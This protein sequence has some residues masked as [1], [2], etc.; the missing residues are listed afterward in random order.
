MANEDYT[1]AT[2]QDRHDEPLTDPETLEQ[3]VIEWAVEV[4]SEGMYALSTVATYLDQALPLEEGPHFTVTLLSALA[5]FRKAGM[6]KGEL[7]ALDQLAIA[8]DN[9]EKGFQ[10]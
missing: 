6:T 4:G 10:Q 9:L 5:I 7:A 2:A 3:A 1:V 8:V